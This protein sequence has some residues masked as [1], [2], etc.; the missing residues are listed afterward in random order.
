ML[1]SCLFLLREGSCSEVSPIH[2]LSG[3]LLGARRVRGQLPY[4]WDWLR[5]YEEGDGS[6]ELAA[7]VVPIVCNTNEDD[8]HMITS[9][10]M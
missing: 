10:R 1:S 5:G 2:E 7:A 3:L 8:V 4:Q 9:G 6:I